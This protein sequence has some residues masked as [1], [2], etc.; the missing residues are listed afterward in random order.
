MAE[1]KRRPKFYRSI[2]SLS[3]STTELIGTYADYSA[4]RGRT[5]S[6]NFPQ[7]ISR[8][9]VVASVKPNYE[10]IVELKP[11]LIV[12]D[13]AL[14]NPTDAEKIK[15]LTKADTFTIDAETVD[16]FIEEIHELGTLLGSETRMSEYAGK[17]HSEMDSARSDPITTPRVAVLLSGGGRDYIAGTKSFLAS[18]VQ[19]A[20]GELVGPTENK[21]VP[22]SPEALVAMNPDLIVVAGTKQNMKGAVAVLNNPKYQ[23]M[24]AIKNRQVR[25]V[26][27]DVLVR[28][29]A[30]VDQ[31]IN[32]LHGLI[33]AG[34]AK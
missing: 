27:E 26:N 11:D 21:F 30:R 31:L 8:V 20:G 16:G 28:R 29:G 6:D 4:L 10:R 33:V 9:E 19:G 1:R 14:F 18:A 13:A 5:A 23:S 25:A 15:S 22:V 34:A 32:A 12:Y 3:P 2:I 24:K 7:S 17:I